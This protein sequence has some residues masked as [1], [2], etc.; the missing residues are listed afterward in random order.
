MVLLNLRGSSGDSLVGPGMAPP[1]AHRT[2]TIREIQ[3]VEPP[4][5]QNLGFPY[6]AHVLGVLS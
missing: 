4:V 6:L 1:V 2:K 5:V 3:V